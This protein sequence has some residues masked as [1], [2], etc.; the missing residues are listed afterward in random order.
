MSGGRQVRATI[1]TGPAGRT[2][3]P[4]CSVRTLIGTFPPLAASGAAT[5]VRGTVTFA[6]G[7]A[8][9]DYGKL[10]LTRR[11]AIPA[12]SYTLILRGA[13]RA[14]FVPVTVQ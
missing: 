12:G 11:R 2:P 7:R 1:C 13:H 6:A 5:L 14:I 8:T 10:T 9:A 4:A 3:T